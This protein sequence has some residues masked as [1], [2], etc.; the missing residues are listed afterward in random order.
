MSGGNPYYRAAD[1]TIPGRPA[2]YVWCVSWYVARVRLVWM[3][4]GRVALAG[5]VYLSNPSS[6]V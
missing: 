4:G 2:S 6:V 3:V 5:V 1:G